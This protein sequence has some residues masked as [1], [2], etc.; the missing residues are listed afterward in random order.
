MANKNACDRLMLLTERLVDSLQQELIFRA[1]GSEE[2]IREHYRKHV[3]STFAD[4]KASG[5]E[6]YQ[7]FVQ[8]LN[9]KKGDRHTMRYNIDFMN[10]Y[11]QSEYQEKLAMGMNTESDI[12]K[13]E[14]YSHTTD[15]NQ[16]NQ[17][18]R[19]FT[20]VFDD[21]IVV[22]NPKSFNP[23]QTRSHNNTIHLVFVN[24][25]SFSGELHVYFQQAFGSTCEINYFIADK[26][27]YFYNSGDH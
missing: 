21:L 3:F 19:F 18:I 1:R 5:E 17:M 7:E 25:A 26:E 20:K 14:D 8:S 22:A 9:E 27:I 24:G 4:M 23:K 10:L 2:E 11:R 15:E 12:E 16:R 13:P 6:D